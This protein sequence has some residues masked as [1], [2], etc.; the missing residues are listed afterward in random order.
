MESCCKLLM[1]LCNLM[2]SILI[3]FCR[4]VEVTCIDEEEIAHEIVLLILRQNLSSFYSSNLLKLKK[5]ESI[6]AQTLYVITKYIDLFPYMYLNIKKTYYM[7][8]LC[9]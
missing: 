9:S 6:A 4:Y 2:G 8:E 3:Q 7:I 1:S 5:I